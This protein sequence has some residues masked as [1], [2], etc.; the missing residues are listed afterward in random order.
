[1]WSPYDAQQPGE[2]NKFGEALV[3]LALMPAPPPIFVAGS[4]G[5]A[6][7]TPAIEAR[8]KSMRDYEALS[9]STAFAA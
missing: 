8:L 2:P 9:S 7:I 3:K 4:D 6:A 1:M 5:L